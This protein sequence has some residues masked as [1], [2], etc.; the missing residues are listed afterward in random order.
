MI[1]GAALMMLPLGCQKGLEDNAAGKADNFTLST[2]LPQ[3][4]TTL[5]HE[6]GY[7]VQWNKN[8][9]L[10]VFNAPAG[11]Q[12]YS[13]NLHFFIEEA[14][15]GKFAPG[16][17]VQVPYE[18]G[19][20]YD[21]FVC[22]PYRATAGSVELKGPAGQSAD[23]GYFPI[24]AATQTGYNNSEHIAGSDIMVGKVTN[25]RTPNVKL[26]HLAV[27][28]RFT[29]TNKSDIPIVITKLTFNGG[30]NK[31]FGTF[32]I[33]LTS[34]NPAIDVTKANATFNE[35][36]LTVKNGTEL[37]V[38]ASADFYM[39]T[40]PFT[41]STGEVFKVTIET[42]TGKQEL[43]KTA[44][45]DIVFAAGTY[46]TAN[47]VYDYNPEFADCLYMDTFDGSQ[48]LATVSSTQNEIRTERWSNY[49]KTG[50]TVYD[51][52]VNSVTYEGAVNSTL[53][54]YVAA[55]ALPRMNELYACLWDNGEITIKGIKLY[56]Y[57]KLNLSFLHAYKNS[58]LTVLYSVDEGAN[59]ITVAICKNAS[60][61]ACVERSLNFELSQPS[62]KISIKFKATGT[63]R[64]RFDNIKLTWQQAE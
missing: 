39:M 6:D 51:G 53:S 54:K 28:H 7:K 17:G 47:L 16:D 25:T 49:D 33:D 42:S 34:D 13:E 15:T 61:E 59:W 24:G 63:T 29:V 20:N 18:D 45:Q 58:E 8:D 46:N 27:L 35:R 56:G 55:S 10:A 62:E 23:D 57:T 41:L 31:L 32:W 4:R 64:P 12:D 9:Q 2:V 19:V 14:A 43:E 50:M 38:D 11:T 60:T 21:W 22:S 1:I 40:A 5:L 30:D 36:A 26:Q 3:T 52:N 48:T 44:Q 37:A